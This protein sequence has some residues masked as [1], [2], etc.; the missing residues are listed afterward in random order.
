MNLKYKIKRKNYCEFFLKNKVGI[1]LDI[2]IFFENEL[3]SLLV[4]IGNELL[5]IK[6]L[7]VFFEKKR[8]I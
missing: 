3:R 6:D 7:K 4:W 2:W 8:V 5:G 1:I